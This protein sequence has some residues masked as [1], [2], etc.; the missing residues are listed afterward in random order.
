MSVMPLDASVE[1]AVTCQGLG[2]S[3]GL[4]LHIH[5]QC[6]WQQLHCRYSVTPEALPLRCYRCNSSGRTERPH[7][8][9][10]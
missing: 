5:R 1:L 9:G 2:L 10:R 3:Y 8:W 7:V 6:E 4:L